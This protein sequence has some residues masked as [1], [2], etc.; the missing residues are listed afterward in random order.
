[1]CDFYR[2]I[3]VSVSI[4]LVIEVIMPA[5]INAQETASVEKLL[6]R[7]TL[8]LKAIE[9]GYGEKDEIYASCFYEPSNIKQGDRTGHWNELYYT[10]GYVHKKFNVYTLFSQ[11]ER[12]D[13]K[14]NT[15]ALGMYV[16]IDKEQYAHLETGFGWDV[17]FIYRLQNIVEYGHRLYKDVFWQCGYIYRNYANDTHLVKPGLIYYFGDSFMAMD[18]GVSFKEKFDPARFVA[19]KGDFAIT[20]FLHWYGGA[21]FGERL[22]DIYELNAAQEKGFI[23]Y[24]GLSLKICKDIKVRAGYSYG[25]ENPKFIKRSIN[26]GINA[27]F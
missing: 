4:F 3:M 21:V 19:F 13:E 5:L 1:M 7:P 27:K 8:S 12:F 23:L 17:D 26:F 14:D 2:K 10:A 24:N 25:S 9:S 18:Y 15:A 22:Y 11:Q 6:E 16:N 20:Q